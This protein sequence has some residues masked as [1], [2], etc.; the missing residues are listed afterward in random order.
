[1]FKIPEVFSGRDE[2]FIGFGRPNAYLVCPDGKGG[3]QKFA[4]K[5]LKR[6]PSVIEATLATSHNRV[7]SF[8]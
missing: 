2:I 4:G 1:M 7:C 5:S 8:G 3:Y 6:A